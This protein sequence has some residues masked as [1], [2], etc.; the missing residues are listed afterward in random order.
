MSATDTIKKDVH[1]TNWGSIERLNLTNYIDWKM[2]VKSILKSMRAWEIVTGE[3]KEPT[4][5]PPTLA[6]LELAIESFKQR[7]NDVETLLR[8][9]VNSTI[10]KQLRRMEDPAEM[11]VTLGNQF[12]RTYSQT[13]RSIHAGNLY[14]VKPHPG[15]RI[16]NYCERLL[17]Y[18]DP[19]DG[20]DE[21]IS[22]S[23][24]L[25]HLFN[26]AGPIFTQTTHDLR[27]KKSTISVQD[28]IDELCE[29][30]RNHLANNQIGD[31]GNNT[32]GT[33]LYS[34]GGKTPVCKYCKKKGHHIND[35]R[36]KQNAQKTSG[37]FQDG[38]SGK[39]QDGH[40]GKFQDG[41]QTSGRKRSRDDIECWHCWQTGHT[42]RNCPLKKRREEFK[43]RRIQKQFGSKGRAMAADVE[44]E[45]LR[46]NL[47]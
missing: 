31:P 6:N 20:T 14:T 42:E 1:R 17:Q 34:N 7:K 47:D 26:N 40:S 45:V 12:N 33:L 27:K 46:S 28:A 39:F 23:V 36:K 25:Q 30:E 2:N 10:Q 9:S 18:R 21:A 13:Q 35:C 11:W 41:Q 38:H 19:V 24:L 8:F 44:E 43:A 22:D 4:E 15:E 37:K 3:E 29:F 16:S 5:T 32:A